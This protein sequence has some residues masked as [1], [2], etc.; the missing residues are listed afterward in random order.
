MALHLW[1]INSN[2]SFYK[3]NNPEALLWTVS[4]RDLLLSGL[5]S[6][7]NVYFNDVKMPPYYLQIF[8]AAV[9][10]YPDAKKGEKKPLNSQVH[11]VD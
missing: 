1:G 4:C 9:Y 6:F 8:V 10:I 2:V 3:K 11:I 7:E 5:G